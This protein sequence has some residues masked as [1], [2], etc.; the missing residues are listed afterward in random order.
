MSQ[1][2]LALLCS[3]YIFSICSGLRAVIS[4]ISLTDMPLFFRI[5]ATLS[6][7]AA[8]PS[9]YPAASPI[10]YPSALPC[11]YPLLNP[12]AFLIASHS[13]LVSLSN[14]KLLTSPSCSIYF[15]F[16]P[17]GVLMPYFLK[18]LDALFWDRPRAAA[19]L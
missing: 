10:S 9:S 8:S 12:S 2:L 13:S 5:L 18:S 16:S 14:K 6:V 11:A 7:H 15:C 1:I 4:Q 19:T 3:R 17:F